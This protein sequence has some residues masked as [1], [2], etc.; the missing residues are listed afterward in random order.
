M[1]KQ[2]LN[3]ILNHRQ[4]S[5]VFYEEKPVWIQEVN[6]DIAKIGFLDG[7]PEKSV[8]IDDLYESDLYK[9]KYIFLFVK[10][11]KKWTFPFFLTF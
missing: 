4:L 10:V 5:E 3:E 11:R 7:S 6:D 8:Y 1:N 2:R 9:S